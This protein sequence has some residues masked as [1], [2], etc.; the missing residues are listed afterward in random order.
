MILTKSLCLALLRPTG[1]SQMPWLYRNGPI[2]RALALLDM[3]KE[4]KKNAVELEEDREV[5]V[6]N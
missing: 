2:R 3:I 5:S 1:T 4:R 6:L